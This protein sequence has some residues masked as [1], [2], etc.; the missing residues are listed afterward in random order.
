MKWLWLGVAGAIGLWLLVLL[1]LSGPKGE[2]QDETKPPFD[3]VSR[4]PRGFDTPAAEVF[5]GVKRPAVKSSRPPGET[6]SSRRLSPDVEEV[7]TAR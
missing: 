6:G 1:M 4:K 2:A 3:A 5:S 7:P